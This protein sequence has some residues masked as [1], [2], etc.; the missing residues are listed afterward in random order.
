MLMGPSRP[1]SAEK[2]RLYSGISK[3][4]A[5]NEKIDHA[6]ILSPPTMPKSP[7]LFAKLFERQSEPSPNSP[8]RVQTA[9]GKLERGSRVSQF[10]HSAMGIVSEQKTL[11]ITEQKTS[12]GGMF[13]GGR[14][15]DHGL[16][17]MLV[18]PKDRQLSRLQVSL[19]IDYR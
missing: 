9:P 1:G 12:Q 7:L 16:E 4:K 18:Q 17:S 14:T 5:R 19:L 10:G 3:S 15:L 2:K 11:S 6:A 13:G 8:P